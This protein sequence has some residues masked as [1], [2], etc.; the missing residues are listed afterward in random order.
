MGFACHSLGKQCFA[1]P[2]R[3]T[4]QH[5]FRDFAPQVSVLFGVFE[6]VHHFEDFVFGTVKAGNV[7]KGDFDRTV[8]VKHLRTALADVEDLAT[9]PARTASAHAAH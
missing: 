6:K 1:S 7:F 2:R 3:A 4:K 5:S 9:R 8:G